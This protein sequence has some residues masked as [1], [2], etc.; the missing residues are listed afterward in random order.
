MA[1]TS[2]TLLPKHAEVDAM[3]SAEYPRISGNF[4]RKFG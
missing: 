3:K 4:S 1:R 2:A